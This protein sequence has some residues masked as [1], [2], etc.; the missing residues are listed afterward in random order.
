MLTV[1]DVVIN[2][3]TEFLESYVIVNVTGVVNVAADK[4]MIGMDVKD[5]EHIQIPVPSLAEYIDS[6]M[7]HVI[8]FN[9]E[10]SV[11]RYF[12]NDVK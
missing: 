1:T 11:S 2:C 3:I 10:Y 12:S 9:Q 8:P 5:S 7:K 4:E 6:Q